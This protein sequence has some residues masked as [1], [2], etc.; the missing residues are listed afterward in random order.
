M[1]VGG[2]AGY[3]PS[4][5]RPDPTVQFCDHGPDM[6]TDHRCSKQ[7]HDVRH[8]KFPLAPLRRA[9]VRRPAGLALMAALAI[10]L[11]LAG[12]AFAEAFFLPTGAEVHNTGD[13]RIRTD[14]QGNLHMVYPIVAGSGAVYAFCPVGCSEA[15]QVRTVDFPTGEAGSVHTALIV[16]DAADTLHLLFSTYDSVIYANCSGD[17]SESSGWRSSVIHEHQADWEL[18]G[19]AFALDQQGRPRFL[20]HAYQAYLGIGAPEPGT[21]LFACDANCLDAANWTGSTISEQSWL[22][23]TLAFDAD[24]VAHVATVIPVGDADLVAYL[25]C[26]VDCGNEE[27]D[28][29]P[30]IGLAEAYSDRYIAEVA[31]AVTMSLTTDGGVR[32]AFLGADGPDHYLAYFECD[33]DCT[34]ADGETWSG[35]ALLNSGEG[36]DLGD[37]IDL[38]LDQQD[39][40][41]LA[42]TVRGSIL[43]AYCDGDCVGR[44]GSV[45]WSLARVELANEIP[46]DDIF[47]YHNCTVGFW[48]LRQPAVALTPDGLPL[49]AYRAEDISAGWTSP[50]PT[51]PSCAVGVDMSMTRLQMVDSY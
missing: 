51:K 34:A 6:S 30:G 48:F 41:R 27:V 18:T 31:P 44:Y 39:R 38:V 43:L 37:G 36:N 50:D 40:P 23:P 7:P 47:L 10:V 15:E 1:R 25:R 46:A 42:Y 20:M 22:E 29:W 35:T 5:P 33:E 8:T 3:S 9:P 2:H 14:S 13:P 16:L 28:N 49:V 11:N 21:R 32:L 45:D 19:S 24:G 4:L 26:D 12:A 17:C